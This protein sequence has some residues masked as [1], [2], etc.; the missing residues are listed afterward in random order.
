MLKT[1]F[2][3][4]P[5]ALILGSFLRERRQVM[6]RLKDGDYRT[7]PINTVFTRILLASIPPIIV[8]SL[9][10]TVIINNIILQ[11]GSSN[12]RD[13]TEVFAMGS[14]E[15][16]R[17]NFKRVSNQLR[18]TSMNMADIIA[19]TDEARESA[20]RMIASLLSL[21]SD[22]Y[23]AWYIF[24]PD[25]IAKNERWGRS[26]LIKDGAL[27]EK[28]ILED[29]VLSDSLLA[30][31]YAEPLNSGEIYFDAVHLY[32]FKVGDGEKYTS[33]IVS[34]IKVNGRIVGCVGANMLYERMFRFM[35]DWQ[36]PNERKVLLVGQDG[37]ILYSTD[38]EYM[39]ERLKMAINENIRPDKPFMEE[40]NSPFYGE[41]S[42]V[43]LFPIDFS[44]SDKM[45]VLYVDMPVKTLYSKAKRSVHNIAL[46][47]A[48]GVTLLFICILAAAKNIVKPIELTTDVAN[49][50]ANGEKIDFY[51][52]KDQWTTLHEVRVMRKSL[53]KMHRQLEQNHELKVKALEEECRRKEIEATSEAKTRFFA[54]M[55]HEIRTPMNAILGISELLMSENLSERQK[56]YAHDIKVSS[57]S[58]LSIINDILD[59]SKFESGNF[60]LVNVHYDLGVMLRNI[61][62]LASFLAKG[63]NLEFSC[64][65]AEDMP[66]Y[67]YGDDVRLRQVLLNLISNAVKYTK[68]GSVKLR[69]SSSEK[70]L[71][72]DVTDTGIGIKNDDMD[73]LFKAF[74]QLDE[75]ENHYIKGTGLG[76]SISVHLAEAMGGKI[77]VSSTYGQGS[78]F[79]V[80]IPKVLGDRA[81]VPEGPE[82]LRMF[83]APGAL[84]LV[85]DDNDINLEVASGMINLY[86]AQCD[87]AISGEEAIEKLRLKEYDVVFMDH[88]MPGID[89]M[90]TT[91]RIRAM[92]G[93]FGD[94][95]V[96]ALSA[97]AMTGMRE[98]FLASG[99][100]DFLSKPI[101]K[102]KLQIMLMKWIPERKIIIK[103]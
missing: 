72:F 82:N 39:N 16:I 37:V 89:G 49:R 69:A 55:S 5:Q 91:R 46:T 9:L 44:L 11:L 100:N 96:I 17:D 24:E 102:N 31:W 35:D 66:D 19:P 30:P 2:L 34:P 23:A 40:M 59:I 4:K 32:D 60:T 33:T 92:G 88:M 101:E 71:R 21:N 42:L 36:I 81:L 68:E 74:K 52:M 28:S 97:N 26:F 75:G 53:R 95:P 87:T 20:D 18:I 48:F 10:L 3:F 85:V 90:E 84:V 57:E 15:K 58:L 80:V 13:T 94:L 8:I 62:S 38:Q 1:L 76:L 61:V 41:T 22:I 67:L 99:M 73:K 86:G 25:V 77:E 56:K 79:S 98:Q 51:E 64:E 70:L 7:K 6:T 78:V 12:T 103:A 50:I 14:Y 47:G 63:K 54:S 93:R 45:L 27:K 43:R 83:S 29:A 65:I